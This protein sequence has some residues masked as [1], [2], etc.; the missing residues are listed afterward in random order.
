MSMGSD[1]HATRNLPYNIFSHMFKNTCKNVC[2]SIILTSKD[3]KQI[4]KY[5][6]KVDRLSELS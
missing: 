2:C 5:L 1:N 3:W 6:L 4:S